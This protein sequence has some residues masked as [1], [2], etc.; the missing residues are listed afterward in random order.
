M[1]LYYWL[2]L[3]SVIVPLAFSFEKNLRLYKQWK[4]I[5][6]AILITM[7]PFVLWDIFFALHGYWGFN[8]RYHSGTIFFGLPMEEY[9]FFVCLPYSSV[10]TYYALQFH[11]PNRMLSKKNVTLLSTCLVLLSA[12]VA[13]SN[14][15]HAYTLVN[16]VLFAIII[17]VTWKFRPKIL[18]YYYWIFLILLVPFF[19]VNGILTGS[20][21]EE[22]VVWYS[23]TA[24]IGIRLF[25]IPIED[26]F[27][28][29]SMIL[30]VVFFA[31]ILRTNHSKKITLL[32]G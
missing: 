18:R 5:V 3:L 29:F 14:T 32:Q 10:F 4:F 19:I 1:S 16:L 8:P 21:I 20:G 28:A 31:D 24:I 11:F 30:S 26:I 7:I 27:F 23:S 22:E 13:L 12:S 6:P 9:L 2:N 25:T 15:Q 17:S